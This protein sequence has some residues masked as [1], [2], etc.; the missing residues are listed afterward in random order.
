[1]SQARWDVHGG[2]VRWLLVRNP[3]WRVQ[4]CFRLVTTTLH[5]CESWHVAHRV[6]QAYPTYA[7]GGWRALCQSCVIQCVSSKAHLGL[8]LCSPVQLDCKKTLVVSYFEL[9]KSAE[10]SSHY[11]RYGWWGRFSPSMCLHAYLF[12]M[13]ED[14][15]SARTV[16]PSLFVYSSWNLTRWFSGGVNSRPLWTTSGVLLA[17]FCH[18]WIRGFRGKTPAIVICLLQCGKWELAAGE[19]IEGIRASPC[20]PLGAWWC[21]TPCINTACIGSVQVMHAHSLLILSL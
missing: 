5:E 14:V 10:P 6:W 2:W 11:V 21:V 3:S 12:G 9:H 13:L 20:K 18:S 15:W 1:M 4:N 16:P 17:C 8:C 19:N 7:R